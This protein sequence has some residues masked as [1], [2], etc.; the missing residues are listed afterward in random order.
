MAE[1][2]LEHPVSPVEQWINRVVAGAA[3]FR[4]YEDC[5][6]AT[7]PDR[8]IGLA[9]FVIRALANPRCEGSDLVLQAIADRR[10]A[11]AART[12]VQEVD[13]G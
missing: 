11:L 13:R 2:I 1:T 3:G 10:K 6:Y 12:P 7:F 4:A 8:D 9:S 5:E